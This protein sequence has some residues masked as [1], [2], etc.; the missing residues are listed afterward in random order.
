MCR[1]YSILEGLSKNGFSELL[2]RQAQILERQ[3]EV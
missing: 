2:R 1:I 3:I